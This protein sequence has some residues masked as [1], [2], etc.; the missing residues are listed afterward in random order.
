M[1]FKNNYF[2]NKDGLRK[3]I[4]P[5]RLLVLA[6]SILLFVSWR[7][8]EIGGHSI[9][10]ILNYKNEHPLFLLLFFIILYGLSVLLLVP[11]LP[12]NLLA[13]AL[14]GGILG[15]IYSAFAVTLGGFLAFLVARF[16]IGQPL[17]GHFNS[18]WM[19]LVSGEF[20][21]K[22]WKFV[23]FARINPVIPTGPLNY[24]L[25]LTTLSNAQFVSSTFFFLLPPAILFSYLGEFMEKMLIN[26]SDFSNIFNLVISISCIITLIMVIKFFLN[27]KNKIVNNE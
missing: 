23:A 16:V 21:Q 22:G 12:L 17:V 8:Y 27:I 3:Y 11:T 24:L 20:E 10:F 7:Y 5:K 15:G 18:R 25:G 26:N 19:E 4:G 6:A 2:A 1:I 14:W 13:G 9:E